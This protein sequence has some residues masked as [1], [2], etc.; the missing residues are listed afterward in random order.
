[1]SRPSKVKGF[2]EAGLDG[3]VA[4]AKYWAVHM[5]ADQTLRDAMDLAL[6]TGQR[7]ADVL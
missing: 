1:M 5:E 3:Y 6:P 2:T 7:P 4:D